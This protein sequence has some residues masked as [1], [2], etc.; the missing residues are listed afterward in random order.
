[1]S[2]EWYMAANI[3]SIG[4]DSSIIRL[5]GVIGSPWT[6]KTSRDFDP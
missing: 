4:P 5:P 1:M 6:G 2:T 3:K